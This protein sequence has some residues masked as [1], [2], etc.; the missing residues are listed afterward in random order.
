MSCIGRTRSEG[1][2]D[3]RAAI[4]VWILERDL[5]NVQFS[6]SFYSALQATLAVRIASSTTRSL[7]RGYVSWI[8]RRLVVER[9]LE[10]RVLSSIEKPRL[11]LRCF[12]LALPPRRS[13]CCCCCRHLLFLLTVHPAAAQTYNEEYRLAA[14]Y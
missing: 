9:R 13:P 7:R 4:S 2:F 3:S 11:P 10:R 5:A 14:G 1:L 12:P 6:K 8:R